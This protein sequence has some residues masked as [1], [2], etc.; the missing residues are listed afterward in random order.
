MD[1]RIVLHGIDLERTQ[2]LACLYIFGKSATVLDGVDRGGICAG[3]ACASGSEPP[4]HGFSGSHVYD[5]P[6]KENHFPNAFTTCL[7]QLL[8]A[9]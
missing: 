8:A 6:A 1:H 9:C 3:G 5:S 4:T 2:L 7:T